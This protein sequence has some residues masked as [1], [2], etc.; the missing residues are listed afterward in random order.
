RYDFFN[1]IAP[2]ANESEAPG[3]ITPPGYFFARIAANSFTNPTTEE[4]ATK[5][6]AV[7]LIDSTNAEQYSKNV[8]YSLWKRVL[9][10]TIYVNDSFSEPIITTKV[11]KFTKNYAVND[12]LPQNSPTDGS[13][14][15]KLYNGL[16]TQAN[17]NARQEYNNVA[18]L[19]EINESIVGSLNTS[20][21]DDQG[22]TQYF[23]NP[24]SNVRLV[25][26]G[27]T[28]EPMIKASTNLK[29]ESCLYVNSG[30]WEDKKTRDKNAAIDQDALKMDF[31]VIDPLGS[32][33][34]SLLVKLCQYKY[35]EHTLKDIDMI[36]L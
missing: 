7:I 5:V 13:I 31:V 6:P 21:L 3:A 30:T 20:F 28:H 12:I 15:M 24:D 22:E 4:A 10:E 2:E 17:W 26:F 8:Y 34:K 32:E 18:V 35:G 36:E 1:A 9:E 14:Q 23:K 25:V 19:N 29:K 33:K 16:F 11:G 27:H